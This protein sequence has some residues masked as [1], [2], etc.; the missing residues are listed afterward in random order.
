M[1]SDQDMLDDDG[2]VDVDAIEDSVLD[3]IYMC[4][5]LHNDDSGTPEQQ[6]ARRTKQREH[7]KR[8]Q[9]EGGNHK[10]LGGIVKYK[11]SNAKP[12]AT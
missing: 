7:L 4:S 12:K 3:D 5:G 11:R 8:Q 6:A 10:V 2:D 9:A 1:A